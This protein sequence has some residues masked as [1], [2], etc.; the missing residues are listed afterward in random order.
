[1]DGASSSETNDAI[2]GHLR[3]AFRE[4]LAL[5]NVPD[6]CPACSKR[7]VSILERHVRPKPWPLGAEQAWD[8]TRCS[9]SS[10]TT[11]R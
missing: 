6:G 5:S 1:M 4:T 8:K 3:Q 9:L 2:T 7:L 11:P 10:S